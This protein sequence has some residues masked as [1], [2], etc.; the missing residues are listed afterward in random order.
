MS[1]VVGIKAS[2]LQKFVFLARFGLGYLDFLIFSNDWYRAT[3]TLP[4]FGLRFVY[5]P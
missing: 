5:S 1:R 4:T 2:K 3:F